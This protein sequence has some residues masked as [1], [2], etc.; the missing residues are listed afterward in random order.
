MAAV[1][2]GTGMLAGCEVIAGIEE[3]E[4]VTASADGG[5]GGDG[6]AATIR[7]GTT[8]PLTG[9]NE[10]IGTEL[11]RGIDA[12][13]A[14]KNKAGGIAGRQ[15]VV[16]VKDDNGDPTKAEAAARA[17]LDVTAPNAAADQ[18]DTRG[19]NG[20][21]AFLAASGAEKTSVVAAKNKTLFFAPFSG[22][23]T[24]LRE[25]T[26]P[27]Y[28]FNMR[29]SFDDEAKAILA[30][31]KK[32]NG[33][34]LPPLKN[35]A[36]FTEE[37]AF[38]DAGFEAVK[39]ALTS[40]SI[41]DEPRRFTHTNDLS[42]VQSAASALKQAAT[43]ADSTK[44]LYVF[45]F[46][47]YGPS[48][49]FIRLLRSEFVKDSSQ[50][51]KGLASTTRFFHV[52]SVGA[53]GL[54]AKLTEPPKFVDGAVAPTPQ[55]QN[56]WVSHVV[57]STKAASPGVQEYRDALKE[58][59]PNAKGGFTSLESQLACRLLLQ[60]LEAARGDTSGD[61]LVKAFESLASVDLGIGV[62]SGYAADKH[63]LFDTVWLSDITPAGDDVEYTVRS[64][65]DPRVGLRA[66]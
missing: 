57:P 54:Q 9:A 15:L 55:Y 23:R 12:C 28:V 21:A 48:N 42:T 44:K 29:A 35:I 47:P 40:E 65:W 66:E 53:E 51:V 18:P 43:T 49:S 38:G 6:G 17:L 25:T 2:A 63:T 16:D 41:T 22:I 24:G 34:A 39:R 32:D 33:D 13:V 52:S 45:L 20:V 8:A 36:V 7:I 3:R 61:A 30:Q 50:Q 10:A 27:K 26:S 31:M 5:A 37:S 58:L 60:G 56:V 4:L 1:S 46:S 62:T 14:R 11:K 19:P 64:R 59:D